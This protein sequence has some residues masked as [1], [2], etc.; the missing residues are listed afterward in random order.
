[1]GTFHL[2]D[3]LNNVFNRTKSSEFENQLPS[4]KL[5][6]LKEI[7]NLVCGIWLYNLDRKDVKETLDST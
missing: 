1:M 7:S 2:P 4:L 6:Q 5:N 3:A